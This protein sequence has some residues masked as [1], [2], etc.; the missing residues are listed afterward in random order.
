M[1]QGGISCITDYFPPPPSFHHS[2]QASPSPPVSLS[3]KASSR[4]TPQTL[5]YR[6]QRLFPPPSFF[7]DT[8]LFPSPN[9]AEPWRRGS[10]LLNCLKAANL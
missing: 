4:F 1:W 7:S 5:V 2:A 3:G 8:Q 6:K 10:E 9:S